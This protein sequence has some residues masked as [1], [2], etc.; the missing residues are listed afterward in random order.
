[1]HKGVNGGPDVRRAKSSFRRNS[2]QTPGIFNTFVTERRTN[3]NPEEISK[4]NES[5]QTRP[6]LRKTTQDQYPKNQRIQ[7][8]LKTS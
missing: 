5:L 1:M 6:F 8:S 3:P 4:S 2:F 7:L